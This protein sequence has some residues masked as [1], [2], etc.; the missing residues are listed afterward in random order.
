[1]LL[2]DFEY[3]RPETLAEA[4]EA[5]ASHGN[6]RVL[7]GG[8]TLLN[9]LKLRLVAPDVLVDVSRL[10]ELRRITVDGDGRLRIGA[11]VTYE[12]IAGSPLVRE[13]HPR[14][15]SMS[16]R[17]VDRQVRARGTLGGNVCLADPTS[18]FPPL[19]VALDST[20]VVHGPRGRRETPAEGFVLAPYA[21]ALGPGELLEEVILPPLDVLDGVGYESLQVGTDSWALAR[22]SALVRSDST[23][24]A[25]RIV[26]GCGAVPVRQPAMEAALVGAEPTPEAI[27]AAAQLAGEAFEPPT[28]V[29]ATAEYRTEM[30][31]VMAARAVAAATGTEL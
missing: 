31:R 4:V 21:T 22:A 15:A 29:H 11:A 1:M 8:Q 14:V 24:S 9:A 23:I 16:A 2:P 3:V 17:L 30:A 25:A 5:L 19:L 27:T 6:A 7:A 10:E 18:N 28:D 20:L 12:E 13:H 26:L